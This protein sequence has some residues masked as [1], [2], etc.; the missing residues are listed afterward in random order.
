[1][2]SRLVTMLITGLILAIT[3]LIVVQFSQ[4]IQ[5][6]FFD[7]ELE[8]AATEQDN[9]QTVKPV[10]VG[11]VSENA[12]VLSINGTS[13]PDIPVAI[14]N[15]GEAIAQ[16]R[17]DE[18]GNWSV[19][20][21]IRSDEPMS[22]RLMEYISDNTPVLADESIYRI[23]APQVDEASVDQSPPA[24]IL[25]TV[26][27]KPS[28]VF[29]S[30]FRGLPTS[31]GISMGS[32]D[33]DESG[34]VIFSGTSDQPGRIRVFANNTAIGEQS[35]DANGRW[36][37]MAADTLGVGQFDIGAA[38]LTESG[39]FSQVTVPFE[40]LTIA[41][42]DPEKE[43]E[44]FYQPYSWQVRR[45]LV[46]GGFQYTVIFAPLRTARSRRYCP[47]IGFF[48]G[49]FN[50]AFIRIARFLNTDGAANRTGVTIRVRVVAN[51]NPQTKA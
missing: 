14:T 28:S 29:Q 44:V 7:G 12:N 11:S 49:G 22:I 3:F 32:I 33:Y 15:F 5:N 41:D 20:L 37:F 43:L 39:T 45:R 42:G 50:R 19:D 8:G 4:T 6:Q 25:V 13:H 38:H 26:P 47:R 40:R 1:V 16:V 17:S 30:P 23:P 48:F 35:V 21:P 9:M 2:R 46:G 24:L 34:G 31:G 10:L 36:Y 27:G 51:D 18:D